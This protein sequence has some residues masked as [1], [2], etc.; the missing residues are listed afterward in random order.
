LVSWPIASLGW[1]GE[2]RTLNRLTQSYV[3]VAIS[4]TATIAV[5]VVAFVMIV[6]LQTVQEW[7]ISGFGL[8]NGDSG[9]VKR[10]AELRATDA[11]D[12]SPATPSGS[13]RHATRRSE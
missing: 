12:R 3:V 11:V 10:G 5:A 2:G 9:G 6:S 4:G 8:G 13:Q 7:P 1:D